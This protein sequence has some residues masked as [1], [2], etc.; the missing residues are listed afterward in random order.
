MTPASSAAPLRGLLLAAGRG[1]RFDASGQQNKLLASVNNEPVA[2][3]AARNLR[4]AVDCMLIVIR[5]GAQ[6]LAQALAPVDATVLECPDA[7]AGMGHSLAFG[8]SNALRLFAPR[9]VL[10][11]LAD[12]PYIQDRTLTAIARYAVGDHVIAVPRFNGQRGHP[13]L[14][15]RAHFAQLQQSVGD[16]GAARLLAEHSGERTGERRREG[17]VE[18]VGGPTDEK[19]VQWLDVDDA[20]VIRDIDRPQDL[21]SA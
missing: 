12:M 1:F 20:G 8:I 11:A 13:V 7:A 18:K 10:L 6:A 9:A 15:G 2:L 21:H 5:P 4:R 19:K 14:F 16:A 17:T 3:I